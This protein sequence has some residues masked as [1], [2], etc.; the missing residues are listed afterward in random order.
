MTWWTMPL[1][2]PLDGGSMSQPRLCS[3][4]KVNHADGQADGMSTAANVPPLD[5]RAK[6][7]T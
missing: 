3:P 1:A 7:H 5:Q 6:S 2:V 4:E